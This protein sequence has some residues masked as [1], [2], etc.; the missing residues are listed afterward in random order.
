MLDR[1]R[2]QMRIRVQEDHRLWSR[3]GVNS[4]AFGGTIRKWVESHAAS[5]PSLL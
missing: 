2:G 5:P 4:R 1:Q 3:R